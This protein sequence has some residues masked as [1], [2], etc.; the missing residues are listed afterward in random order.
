M[1]WN[2]TLVMKIQMDLNNTP[3]VTLSPDRSR[4]D[5]IERHNPRKARLISKWYS[6]ILKSYTSVLIANKLD[7]YSNMPHA[8]ASHT[9]TQSSNEN[10]KTWYHMINL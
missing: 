4:C 2:V 1:A 9:E 5:N 10:F 7:S 6:Y 8:F 3:Y